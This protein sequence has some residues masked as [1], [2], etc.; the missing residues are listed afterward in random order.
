MAATTPPK[1]PPESPRP[2]SPRMV[3]GMTPTSPTQ[4]SLPIYSPTKADPFP[5]AD[6]T[7]DE[8]PPKAELVAKKTNH[9]ASVCFG[10]AFLFYGLAAYDFYVAFKEKSFSLLIR[11]AFWVIVAQIIGIAGEILQKT[12]RIE[13]VVSSNGHAPVRSFLEKG[14]FPGI[15]NSGN[16]CFINAPTQ[17]IMNDSEYPVVFKSICVRAKERHESFKKFLELYPSL[18]FWSSFSFGG[19]FSRQPTESPTLEVEN[20]RDVMAMLM[21]RRSDLKYDTQ[22]FKQKYPVFHQLMEEFLK[23]KKDEDLPQQLGNATAI[24]EEFGKMTQDPEIVRFFY[25]ERTSISN[26]LRGFEAYLNL[27]QE[28]ERAVKSKLSVVSLRGWGGSLI[29]DIR[30]L[31]GGSG[32]SS[33]EDPEEFLHCLSKYILP[34]DYPTVFF[35]FFYVRKWA[36]CPE[37]EQNLDKPEEI[38]QKHRNPTAPSDVLTEM[39]DTKELVYKSEPDCILRIEGFLH[40]NASGEALIRQTFAP[41]QSAKSSEDPDKQTG[42][43]L[44]RTTGKP[45][46]FYLV[47]ETLVIEPEKMPRCLILQL[48]RY[49]SEGGVSKRI[50]V[51]INMPEKMKING[52]DYQLNSV[53]VHSTLAHDDPS[54]T[55]RGHYYTV[56][57]K[58][59][60][61]FWASD[62]SVGQAEKEHKEQAIKHGFLYFYERIDSE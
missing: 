45:K 4:P 54:S 16:T 3:D 17:A 27:I 26:Q 18:S 55:E 32:S 47:Q 37:P 49:K 11:G 38:L 50:D 12:T 42:V 6:P 28:Y 41:R 2:E 22:E 31:M 48:K 1:S 25:E 29:G 40:E 56:A 8:A 19:L 43:F 53:V 60:S 51:A 20:L 13:P 57:R 5:I 33:Q 23:A 34:D 52:K 14:W 24:K 44:D 35:P 10:I 58:D 46:K 62:E 21:P 36:E 9:G 59:R 15:R 30:Y 61:W 7:I 39:P